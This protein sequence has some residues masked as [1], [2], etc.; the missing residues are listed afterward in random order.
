MP[1]GLTNDGDGCQD[2]VECT[3]EKLCNYEEKI[4]SFYEE[5]LHTDEEIRFVVDGSGEMLTGSRKVAGSFVFHVVYVWGY[6]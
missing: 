4:K 3:P 5:H 6:E 2:M 1:F